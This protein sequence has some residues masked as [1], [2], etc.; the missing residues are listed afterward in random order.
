QGLEAIGGNMFISTPA[1]GE[2]IVETQNAVAQPSHVLQGHL[3]RSNVL[4]ADEMV[5]LIVSQRAF[6]L[7]SRIITTSDDMLQQ[8]NNMRR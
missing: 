8:A 4:I 5:N 2:P 3:E 7:N 6:E 1:S